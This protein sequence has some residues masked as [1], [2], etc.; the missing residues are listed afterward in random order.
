MC[1]SSFVKLKRSEVYGNT[2]IHSTKSSGEG[3][4]QTAMSM[5]LLCLL[6]AVYIL[7][8]ISRHLFFG[9]LP[10]APGAYEGEHHTPSVIWFRAYSSTNQCIGICQHRR[11]SNPGPLGERPELYPWSYAPAGVLCRYF[12]SKLWDFRLLKQNQVFSSSNSSFSPLDQAIHST[13]FLHSTIQTLRIGFSTKFNTYMNS[14]HF[15][16]RDF[17]T[18]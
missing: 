9:T 13:T 15:N 12:V 5:C 6:A 18:R 7:A 8:K 14:L 11:D 17:K 10:P 3:I 16:F 1:L 4:L 2:I